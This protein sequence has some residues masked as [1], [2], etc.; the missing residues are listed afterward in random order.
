M[1]RFLVNIFDGAIEEIEGSFY[2]NKSVYS[3]TE[4]SRFPGGIPSSRIKLSSN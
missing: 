2:V 1:K 3:D 4:S